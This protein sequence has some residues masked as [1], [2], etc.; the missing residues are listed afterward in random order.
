[1]RLQENKME[2]LNIR[3]KTGTYHHHH[4]HHHI[5]YF[6]AVELFSKE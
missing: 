6:T 4:H 3:E 1:M 5:P 2:N